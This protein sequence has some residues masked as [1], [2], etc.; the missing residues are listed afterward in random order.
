MLGPRLDCM[1]SLKRCNIPTAKG[2][3]PMTTKTC[4]TLNRICLLICDSF[5][6]KKLYKLG[7]ISPV[8]A[9]IRGTPSPKLGKTYQSSSEKSR[10]KSIPKLRI[11]N[12]KTDKIKIIIFL[13]RSFALTFAIIFLIGGSVLPEISL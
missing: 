10:Q 4:S 7:V 13:I 1:I 8:R 2:E 5:C 9:I 6:Y 12:L 3:N 11:R